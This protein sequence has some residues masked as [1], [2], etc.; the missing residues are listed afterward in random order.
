[1][2]GKLIPI[3]KSKAALTEYEHRILALIN[4]TTECR[5]SL[6]REKV[7]APLKLRPTA[8]RE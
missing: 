2:Y 4:V 7:G 8:H 1:M 3:D 5:M 6:F